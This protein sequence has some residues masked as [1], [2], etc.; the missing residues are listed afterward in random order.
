M[1]GGPI[2]QGSAGVRLVRRTGVLARSSVPRCIHFRQPGESAARC[3]STARRN[4]FRAARPVTVR[5]LPHLQQLPDENPCAR[6]DG[7]AG[8]HPLISAYRYAITNCYS[9]TTAEEA[10]ILSSCCRVRRCSAAASYSGW[11]AA[12]RHA[13]GQSPLARLWEALPAD[14]RLSPHIDLATNSAQGPWWVLGWT[15][16]VPGTEAYC[17]RRCRRTGCDRAG[18]PLRADADV[19]A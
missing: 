12:A 7:P 15:E 17:L 3:K 19:P 11:Y 13:D 18:G 1:K 4:R 5:A 2:V 6:R 9:T 8:K 10:F 14:L 16:R